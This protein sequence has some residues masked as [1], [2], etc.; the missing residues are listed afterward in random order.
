MGRK[1][2]LEKRMARLK[3]K[4]EELRARALASNDAAEV[5]GINEQLG[6]L[7]EEIEETQEEIDC[8][9]EDDPAGAGDGGHVVDDPSQRSNLPAGATRSFAP[10]AAY[11]Q[12]TNG[13]PA[14]TEE[15]QEPFSSVEYRSAFKNYVQT[16]APITGDILQRAGGD[17]G[18]TVSTDL[19]AIIPSTIMNEFIKEVSK[20]RGKIYAKVRKLNVQGGIKFPISKL[21]AQFKWITETT[22]SGKQKAGEIKEFIEFSYNIGEIRV[23]QTLLSQVVSLAVFE[24]E[25]VRI[26]TEA[27]VEMMDSVIISGTGSGQPLGI[28][29]DSR[30]TN[31]VEMTEEEFADWTAWRKKLFAVVPLAKRGQ[32]EF[33]FPPST[34]ESY[35]YTMKDKN[36][37]PLYKEA[38][39]LTVGNADGKFFG[40]DVDFVE[41]DVIADF[42]TAAAGDVVGI[43]WVPGD[44]ALNTNMQFG[45]KRYFDEDT[46]EWINKGLTIVDGKILDT[47]G[48]YLIKKKASA[49]ATKAA[50]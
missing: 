8:L 13:D 34:V 44:Y 25:I 36:D 16:G 45:M 14:Q 37:R 21:K 46:N 39:D 41:P 20:V 35:L 26:M 32:G 28:T 50:K 2:V 4:S 19:G 17:A 18:T 24:Q 47:A 15:R 48:C 38:T 42:G 11:R 12:N 40:R 49:A 10:M 33:L 1:K 30:V 31:V 27:Y 6:E 5:R 9:G 22:V 23:A 29:K 7:T 3:K 43:F